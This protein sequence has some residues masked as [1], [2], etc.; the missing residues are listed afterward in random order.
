[1]HQVVTTG[2]DECGKNPN[3][4]VNAVVIIQTHTNL[5]GLAFGQTLNGN[6]LALLARYAVS[7]C[8]N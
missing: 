3:T 6:V 5:L 1:M 8:S 7:L 2:T 4:T